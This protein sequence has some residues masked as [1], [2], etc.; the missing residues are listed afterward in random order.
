MSI[1]SLIYKLRDI[2]SSV[3]QR[4]YFHILIVFSTRDSILTSMKYW[5]SLSLRSRLDVYRQKIVKWWILCSTER[6][7]PLDVAWI[8]HS[9]YHNSVHILG[10]SYPEAYSHPATTSFGPSEGDTQAGMDQSASLCQLPPPPTRPR[11]S[12]PHRRL[13]PLSGHLFNRNYSSGP[14]LPCTRTPL[15]RLE[16][17]LLG[18]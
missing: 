2:F 13:L 18:K 4:W 11:L 1:K 6:V 8:N 10:Y 7:K 3:L 5:V 14:G 15:L 9:Q 17:R 16:L 12:Q